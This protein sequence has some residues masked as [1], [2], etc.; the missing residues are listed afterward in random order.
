MD[1]DFRDGTRAL[2]CQRVDINNFHM[3]TRGAVSLICPGELV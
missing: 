2:R 3:T 1:G